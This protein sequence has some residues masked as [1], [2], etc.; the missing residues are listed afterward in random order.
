MTSSRSSYAVL[1]CIASSASSTATR[2]A[3]HRSS[4]HSCHKRLTGS[5]SSILV[6]SSVSLKFVYLCVSLRSV[7]CVCYLSYICFFS[8][9]CF[10]FL[11]LYFLCGHL[12]I[13]FLFYLVCQS[14]S[15][16]VLLFSQYCVFIP[17]VYLCFLC[18]FLVFFVS[19]VSSV[20]IQCVV[21]LSLVSRLLCVS[22]PHLFVLFYQCFCLPSIHY[23]WLFFI[24][25]FCVLFLI[26]ISVFCLPLTSHLVLWGSFFHLWLFLP[27]IS[28]PCFQ[29]ISFVSG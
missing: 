22:F 9:L 12:L 15:L 3:R 11:S 2:M 28:H 21:C 7:L 14:L 6:L 10:V 13:C 26:S 17:V 19:C 29:F 18:L 5:S 27:F 24:H 1:C 25:V 4:R 20:V 16:R 23:D 8:L